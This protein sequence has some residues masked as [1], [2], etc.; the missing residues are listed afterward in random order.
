[1]P[2]KGCGMISTQTA[3][4]TRKAG[5][6]QVGKETL[7]DRLRNVRAETLKPAPRLTLSQWARRYAR[8]S[9]ENSAEAGAVRPFGYQVGIMDAMTDPKLDQVTVMKSARLGYTMII[10][11]VA[12][13]YVHSDPSHVLIVQPT[14]ADAQDHATSELAPLFRASPALQAIRNPVAKGAQQDRWNHWK[15]K[16]GGSLRIRGAVA[17]DTFR[18]ISTRINIG[19]EIDAEGWKP[20]ANTQGDKLKLLNKRGEGFWNSKLILGSTPLIK[21]ESQVEEQ[22]HKGDQRRFFVPC[23]HCGTEQYLEWGGPETDHGIKFVRDDKGH[24]EDVWYECAHCHEAIREE[25]KRWMNDNGRWIATAEP[26]K[27]GHASFHISTLYSEFPKASWWNLAEE[28]IEAQKDPHNLLQPF[29]NLVLGD[30][31]EDRGGKKVDPESYADTR[32]EPYNAEIPD[33]VLVLTAGVDVQSGENARLEYEVLGVGAGEENWQIEYGVIHGDPSDE[34]TWYRLDEATIDRT[35]RDARGR[36]FGIQA[37]S[38]D[39]GGHHGHEVMEYAR[40]R[41]GRRVF[42]VKG[43]NP[44]KG[45]REKKIW[46]Q[47]PGRKQRAEKPFMIGTQLA[48]DRIASMLRREEPGPGYCHFPPSATAAYFRGLFAEKK[49]YRQLGGK[50]VTYWDDSSVTGNEPGDCRVYAYAAMQ[51]LKSLSSSWDLDVLARSGPIASAPGADNGGGNKGGGDAPKADETQQ[52][53]RQSRQT[54][55]LRGRGRRGPVRSSFV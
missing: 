46:P 26:E 41:R 44:T 16:T 19:D 11:L 22:Y 43:S 20:G 17:D 50:Y 8:L 29:F 40:K 37:M 7:R 45:R 30:T 54:K 47:R 15:F 12:G 27:P 10:A 39:H 18:R 1:M 52:Q 13:Y 28:W 31:W 14:D 21:G 51:A 25:H 53:N 23:P 38:V 9:K 32:P 6:Y 2:W 33:G 34:D 48:K 55:P 5:D 49:K 36:R 24:V 4:T 3:A 42:A 35:W